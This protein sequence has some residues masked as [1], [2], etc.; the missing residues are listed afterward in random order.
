MDIHNSSRLILIIYI[1]KVKY[2]HDITN[3][4]LNNEN[5]SAERTD[6]GKEFHIQHVRGT[7]ENRKSLYEKRVD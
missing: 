3:Q 5:E 4:D 6:I 1:H 7:K 2:Y